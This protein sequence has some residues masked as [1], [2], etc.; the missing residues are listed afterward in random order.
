MVNSPEVDMV[1]EVPI[2]RKVVPIDARHNELAERVAKGTP[3]DGV[4]A[5][6]F[7][8]LALTRASEVGAALPAVLA[9]SLCIVVQGRKRAFVGNQTY[10][11]DPFNYLLVS[12][13]LP[14]RSQIIDASPERPYLCIRLDIDMREVGRLL[15]ET[16]AEPAPP[17]PASAPLYVAR[18]TSDLTEVLLRLL[19]LL[20]TPDDLPML[21]PLAMRE[22]W[23]RLLR[24]DMGP[25]LR[26]L[27]EADGAVQRIS[28]AIQLL[29]KHFKETLRIQDLAEVAHMSPSTFHARFKAVT[30]MSPLQ[31]QKH[32][33]LHEARR[34]MMIGEIDAAEAGHLVGYESPSQ[35]S[36]EY[37]RLFGA[38]PRREIASRRG[39]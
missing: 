23:Y 11:Y 10:Q 32:L 28:R 16:K 14:V 18:M 7:A 12:L 6:A 33:R 9:P 15:L 36:R 34:L 20:D 8:P 35:F 2:A 26:T 25:R 19:R 38:P 21:G 13:S 39:A 31:F 30:D 37:R 3:A 17:A 22:I 27:T 1:A 24:G 4:H 5:T 29:Q